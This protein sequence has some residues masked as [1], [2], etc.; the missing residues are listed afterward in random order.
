MRHLQKVSQPLVHAAD[1]PVDAKMEF[2]ISILTAFTPILQ[3]KN[4]EQTTP[5]PTE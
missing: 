3:A 2:I 5:T 4:P 1:I